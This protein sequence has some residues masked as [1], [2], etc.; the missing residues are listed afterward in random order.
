MRPFTKLAEVFAVKT[1]GSIMFKA[2]DYTG[3][4]NLSMGSTAAQL[5]S[6]LNLTYS[7][8]T[9]PLLC[10]SGLLEK[11]IPWKKLFT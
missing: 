9:R 4:K 11:T 10:C 7:L 8:V 3:K 6:T 1:A 5:Y 2:E